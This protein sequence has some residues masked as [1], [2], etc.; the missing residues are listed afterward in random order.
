MAASEVEV[1]GVRVRPD[2]RE[3][4]LLHQRR[5][6]GSVAGEADP[7]ADEDVDA[8]TVGDRGDTVQG[9]DHPI[10]V[11]RARAEALGG[12]ADGL[13]AEE[14]GGG[15]PGEVPLDRAVA[16]ALVVRAERPRVHDLDEHD[17][18][19]GVVGAL[20]HVRENVSRAMCARS[21]CVLGRSRISRW[22]DHSARASFGAAS[23]GLGV[24]AVF[25]GA[26]GPWSAR[27]NGSRRRA[28]MVLRVPARECTGARIGAVQLL[29]CP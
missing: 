25:G 18:H 2:A 29:R 4:R 5:R 20:L 22:S 17:L 24:V 3:R 12:D 9:V 13:A 10:Q 21:T 8:V 14:R 27:A 26:S 19:A 11:R 6:P 23:A 28:S 7:V 15:D 16:R 1:V